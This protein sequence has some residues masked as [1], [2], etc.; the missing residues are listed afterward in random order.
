M[1]LGRVLKKISLTP[2]SILLVKED[3]DFFGEDFKTV[4][5]G[6]AKIIGTT[7]VPNVVVLGIRDFDDLKMMN[8]TAM[9][10]I[11][12][13]RVTQLQKLFSKTPIITNKEKQDD[14]ESKTTSE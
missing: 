13:F 10:Q 1:K 12:W 6:L 3:T 2:N 4:I 11:G 7:G 9:N 8:E 5:E 14:A